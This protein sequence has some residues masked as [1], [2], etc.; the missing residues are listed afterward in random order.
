MNRKVTLAGALLTHPATVGS[1]PAK[2]LKFK[3]RDLEDIAKWAAWLLS[4]RKIA[5]RTDAFLVA[6]KSQDDPVAHHAAWLLCACMAST[7]KVRQFPAKLRP[8]ALELVTLAFHAGARHESI[9]VEKRF[10]DSV[11]AITAQR[12]ALPDARA[13]RKRKI[14]IPKYKAANAKARTLK[15]LSS[16]LSASPQAVRNFEAQNP[17]LKT[18]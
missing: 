15:E 14:T 13:N 12:A 18:R 1:E 10:R 5:L 2:P 8:V 11:S 7:G 16:L 6:L 17:A 3:E 9:T 4:N